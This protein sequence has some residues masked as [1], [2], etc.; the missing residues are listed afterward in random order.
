MNPS[1]DLCNRAPSPDLFP[2]KTGNASSIPLL[3]QIDAMLLAAPNLSQFA[4]NFANWLRARYERRAI[5]ETPWY[6]TVIGKWQKIMDL[7]L[8]ELRPEIA[9]VSNAFKNAAEYH[10]MDVVIATYEATFPA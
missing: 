8:A 3:A 9:R 10:G 5:D 1:R 2:M 4:E 7:F 6:S